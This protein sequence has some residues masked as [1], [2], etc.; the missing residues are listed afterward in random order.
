M[1]QLHMQNDKPQTKLTVLQQAVNIITSLEGAVRG[2]F[3]TT[4]ARALKGS[5]QPDIYW[6]EHRVIPL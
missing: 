2:R 3:Y 5:N 6:W 1:C 4:H